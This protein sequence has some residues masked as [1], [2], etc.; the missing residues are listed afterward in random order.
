MCVSVSV[1]VCV[2]VFASDVRI[3]S[4]LEHADFQFSTASTTALQTC[5]DIRSKIQE[6]W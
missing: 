2:C 6:R 4:G 1:C 5:S 3:R